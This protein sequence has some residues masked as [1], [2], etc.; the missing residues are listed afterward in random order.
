MFRQLQ[1][2]TSSIH[3]IIEWGHHWRSN[4]FDCA[5]QHYDHSD[6]SQHCEGH[7][8][9][10]Y[11]RWGPWTKEN[12][13][14]I[15]WLGLWHSFRHILPNLG[16]RFISTIKWTVRYYTSER[17]RRQTSVPFEL[18]G[19]LFKSLLHRNVLCWH[20]PLHS[21]N[22]LHYH[23]SNH[24]SQEQLDAYNC[25]IQVISHGEIPHT[26]LKHHH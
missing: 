18:R 14:T 17:Q 5:H 11:G 10:E 20:H 9:L 16:C 7:N 6:Y 19:Y 13:P 4:D 8:W 25:P 15:N 1:E 22:N 3:Q 23:P 24:I 12:K 26:I 21:P 2:K